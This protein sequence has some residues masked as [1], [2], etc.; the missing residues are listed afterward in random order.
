MKI[1]LLTASLAFA[2]ACG[3]ASDRPEVL[4][5]LRALG[6]SASPLVSTPSTTGEAARTVELTVYT[7]LPE[8]H[9]AEIAPYKDQETLAAVMLEESEIAVQPASIAYEKH[10]GLQVM[11]FKALLAVPA[12]ER[13]ARTGGAGQVRYG[14]RVT[15]TSDGEDEKIIGN[16]LVYPQGAPELAWEHPKVSV[17]N[18]ADAGKL[19]ADSEVAVTAALVNPNTE[20]LTVGWFAS[21]GEIANRRAKETTWK[22]PGAGPQTLLVT[23]RG[24]KSR[25]FGWQV[26]TLNAE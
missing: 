1:V 11:S 18:L 17:T 6:A 2:A 8:G 16:F 14:F 22:T 7:V 4:D 19:A 20:E 10:A 21:G 9:A 13:F 15:D 5:K 25:G 12:A 23:V 26:L 3:G 24:K